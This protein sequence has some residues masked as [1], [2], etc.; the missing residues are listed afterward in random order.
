MADTPMSA[1]FA[2]EPGQLVF[3]RRYKY[4]GV[5]V[6]RDP[7]CRADDAWYHNNQTQ[8]KRE[9]PW[10]HVLVHGAGHMTYVAQTNLTEDPSQEP[11]EHPM[12]DKFFKTFLQGRYYKDIMN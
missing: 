6:D 8:P 3:H 12:L 9:Q 1:E 5:V 11:I 7:V 10:Y 4:R 2:F